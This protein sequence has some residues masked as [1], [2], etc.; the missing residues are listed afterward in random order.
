MKLTP[1][2]QVVLAMLHD[3]WRI[4]HTIDSRVGNRLKLMRG[5][6]YGQKVS[7]RTL[8]AMK[9]EG[10]VVFETWGNGGATY[11]PAEQDHGGAAN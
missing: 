7:F 2:Q 6:E 1:H 11:G 10:A 3:G 9:L 8:K 5:N 4:V